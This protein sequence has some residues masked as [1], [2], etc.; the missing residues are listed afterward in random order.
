[1]TEQSINH[2]FDF[3]LGEWELTWGED[4]HGTNHIKRIMEGAVIHENFESEGYQ[5]MSVSVF[6]KEDGHWH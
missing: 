1:M 2:E 6:S 5:G 4:D 3:W